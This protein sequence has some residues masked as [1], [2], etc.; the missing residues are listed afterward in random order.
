MSHISKIKINIE[1]KNK[2][3]ILNAV[4]NMNQIFPNLKVKINEKIKRALSRTRLE[5]AEEVDILLDFGDGYEIGLKQN[6][7]KYNIVTDEW[8]WEEN[9]NKKL[10]D[11]YISKIQDF[12]L[13][14]NLKLNAE[15]EG[16]TVNWEYNEKKEEIEF[17]MEKW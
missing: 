13:L 14:E 15:Q 17:E 9:N 7:D 10:L 8:Y 5:E 1:L 11:K 2:D 16:Y 6:F 3:Q 12:Y 4:K